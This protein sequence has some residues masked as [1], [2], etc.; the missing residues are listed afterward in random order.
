MTTKLQEWLGRAQV[1]ADLDQR[2]GPPCRS[3]MPRTALVYRGSLGYAVPA[4]VMGPARSS[5]IWCGAYEAHEHYRTWRV[6]QVRWA[7]GGV[8]WVD[9]ACLDAVA[10]EV[11]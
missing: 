10:S 6:V 2:F 8:G 3:E 5:R 9:E 11:A 1:H 4:W 7:D